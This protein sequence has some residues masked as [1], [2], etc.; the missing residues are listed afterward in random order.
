MES[1]N[2]GKKKL[3]L[4]EVTKGGNRVGKNRGFR[5]EQSQVFEDARGTR[6]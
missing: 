5:D 6:R 4:L 2:V 1:E 3:L